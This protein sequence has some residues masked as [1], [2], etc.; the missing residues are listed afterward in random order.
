MTNSEKKK[1]KKR[2]QEYYKNILLQFL[3]LEKDIYPH[4]EHSLVFYHYPQGRMI[5]WCGA[6]KIQL[7]KER[8]WIYNADKYIIS[9][10]L[11]DKS[12]PKFNL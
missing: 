12:C 7:A 8:R 9:N 5:L 4:S 11:K 1:L 3:G 6:N 10:I 2:Y